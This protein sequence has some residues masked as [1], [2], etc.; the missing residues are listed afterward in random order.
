MTRKHLQRIDEG[1]VG[2]F[3]LHAGELPLEAVPVAVQ[4][5]WPGSGPD[6]NHPV[7]RL[8]SPSSVEGLDPLTQEAMAL[9]F[10]SVVMVTNRNI[11][12]RPYRIYDGGTTFS[13]E[14][15]RQLSA[16]RPKRSRSMYSGFDHPLLGQRSIPLD[17]IVKVNLK[18]SEVFPDSFGVRIHTTSLGMEGWPDWPI[19]DL[20]SQARRRLELHGSEGDLDSIEAPFTLFLLEEAAAANF[21]RDFL[22]VVRDHGVEISWKPLSSGQRTVY[23]L[24]FETPNRTEEWTPLHERISRT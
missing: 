7:H 15:D 14:V 12:F 10:P 23:E 11:H 19:F 1:R 6:M 5:G 18:D 8:L 20:G 4:A 9:P 16:R 24:M 2:L 17:Q 3:E 21:A 22:P 13:K